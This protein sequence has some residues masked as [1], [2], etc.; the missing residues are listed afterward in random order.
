MHY[1][2][3][4][5]YIVKKQVK[6]SKITSSICKSKNY[7]HFTKVLFDSDEKPAFMKWLVQLTFGEYFNHPIESLSLSM[8]P[9]ITTTNLRKRF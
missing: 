9:I 8:A 4:S 7:P 2:F 5:K 6:Y 1:S 3:L